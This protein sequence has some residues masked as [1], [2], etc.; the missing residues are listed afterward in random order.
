MLRKRVGLSVIASSL[1]IGA[2]L[3]ATTLG[4]VASTSHQVVVQSLF[5][6]PA[7]GTS[8]PGATVFTGIFASVEPSRHPEAG[9]EAIPTGQIEL[10]QAPDGTQSVSSPPPGSNEINDLATPGAVH[11]N[12]ISGNLVA[13]FEGPPDIPDIF[14]FFSVPPD[15]ITAA[16][17]NH[18]IGAVNTSF[19]IFNKSGDMQERVDATAW[20]ENVLPGLGDPQNSPLGHAF[21]PK[22][23]Y[24]HFED[25]WVI[26]YL[27]VDRNPTTQSWILVSVSDDA[28]P[29]GNWCNWALPG[30][31]NGSTHASNWSDYQGLGFDDQAVYVVPNQFSFSR[32]FEYAKLRILPKS[33]LYNPSCPAI[34][35]T[36]FWD[37]RYPGE[38]LDQYAV[39]T[40]RPAV[41]FGSPGVEYLMTNSG[42]LPPYNNFM[43]LYSLTN[44]L[45]NPTLT[46]D[47]VPVVSSDPPPNAN[48]RGGSTPSP[49]LDPNCGNPCLIDVGGNRIRN[50]VYRDG[51]LWTSHNVADVN[52]GQLA[53]ARYVRVN[54]AG[55]IPTEDVSLGSPD[56]W[57][58][59]PAIT[60]DTDSNMVMVFNRSC[61]DNAAQPEYAG[62]RFTTRIDGA[63][64]QPSEGLKAGE[65]NYV[66]TYGGSRNR[67]GDYSGAAVDPADPSS[68]WI[69]AEYAAF[70]QDTWGTWF[71]QVRFTEARPIAI[72]NAPTMGDE[73]SPVTFDGSQSMGSNGSPIVGYHWDFGDGTSGDGAV[74]THTF[75]DDGRYDVTLTVTDDSGASATGTPSDHH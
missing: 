21:D 25:R 50:V 44:P 12:A 70:P 58:Y 15:P 52:T 53:R 38:E 68:I 4:M 45:N 41:T 33:T 49:E 67:W 46:A 75:E 27:A 3:W 42:F 61:S 2:G 31:V 7:Q 72:I 37:L 26:V 69:F 54:V 18:L 47:V 57:Y 74:V 60:T 30:D 5:Q 62:I 55:L 36:D 19:E 43:V 17:P 35:W 34:T 10:V 28:D 16:G 13:S 29:H 73:G 48:Q 64:L 20:F 1:L 11:P 23:I 8:A 9:A 63:E 39:A 24:D 66:K 65:A 59:Y 6:G 14:G 71:G 22:V 51:S 56:C 32:V 40:V